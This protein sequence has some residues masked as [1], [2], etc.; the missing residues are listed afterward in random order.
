MIT[1]I[2]AGPGQNKYMLPAGM[3]VI[4]TA[5]IVI[6]DKRYVPEIRHRDV[7]P[8]GSVMAA[9]D[10]IGRLS[11]TKHVA[12]VV[13]GDP[14]MYSLYKT[15]KTKLPD[16]K[17]EVIP[18]IGSMQFLAARLGETLEDAVFLS[19]HGR[20]LDEGKLCRAAAEHKKVFILCDHKKGPGWIG[21]VLD[22]YGWG[23]LFMSAASCLSYDNETIVSG[24]AAS[25]AGQDFDSLS[26]VFIKNE[27]PRTAVFKP[28]LQDDDFIRGK[29]PMTKEEIRWMI[30]GKLSLKPDAVVWDI[31]AGTGSVSVECAR[32]CPFGRVY[33]IERHTEAAELIRKN[34]E[35][36]ELDNLEI[37]EG[38]AGNK[39]EGLP[40]PTHIFIG[41]SGREMK[42]MIEKIRG[43]GAGIKVVIACVTVETL[44]EAVTCLKDRF[45]DFSMVQA[46]V[47][48]SRA[49]GSYHMIENNNT[50]TLVSGVTEGI[51]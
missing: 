10:E 6:A 48:R 42:T 26:V 16:K 38:M 2:G 8:M 27:A 23:N 19:A 14:L 7:R 5:D 17:I 37:I 11:Q 41:G 3:E 13:S 1:V 20:N 47:G 40:I 22:Q 24:D 25:F 4:K 21:G 9:I 51:H 46:S 15:I 34:K 43:M 50:V 28:L 30:L 45:A 33:A 12:V 29:A 32:Q 36:F 35:K 49:L 44:A 39:I 18:G 31:G